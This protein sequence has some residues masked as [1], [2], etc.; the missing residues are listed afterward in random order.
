MRTPPTVS[1]QPG[2]GAISAGGAT[3][4]QQTAC[5]AR[6]GRRKWRLLFLCEGHTIG[7]MQ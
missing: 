1:V 2:G 6:S 3:A 4:S 5:A 7:L